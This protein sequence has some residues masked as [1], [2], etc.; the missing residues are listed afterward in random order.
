MGL[1]TIWDS[2]SKSQTFEHMGLHVQDGIIWDFIHG[3]ISLDFMGLLSNVSYGTIDNISCGTSVQDC[4]IW[5]FDI[6][7]DCLSKCNN[8]DYMGLPVQY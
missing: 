7:W 2:L 1:S 3:H 6:I 8:F 5:D 4:I